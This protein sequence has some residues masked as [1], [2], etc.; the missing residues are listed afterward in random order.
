MACIDCHGSRDTHNGTKW[1]DPTSG[2]TMVDAPGMFSKMDQTVGVECETCHGNAEYY[3][4]TIQ[5][6][7]YNGATQ[8]CAVD[9]FGNPMRNVAVDGNGNA[10]L[11]SRLDQIRHFIPQTRDTV[12]DTGKRHPINNTAIYSPNA[13]Y[14]MGRANDFGNQNDGVGPMQI[15]PN[16][17][18]DNFSHMDTLACD[19]CHASWNNN[20]IGCHLQ[21]AYNA[22]PA[23]F[24]F[25]N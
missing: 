9:R 24:F 18:P 4:D 5:C 11:T 8:N 15:N 3:A 20:C 21:L 7:D 10:W 13:S 25:S 6:E 22:N 17:V 14:A 19:A 16:L 12:V 1:N 23:N 2:T